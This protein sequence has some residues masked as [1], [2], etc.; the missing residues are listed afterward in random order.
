MQASSAKGKGFASRKRFTGL[1]FVERCCVVSRQPIRTYQKCSRTNSGG[2]GATLRALRSR[3]NSVSF[4]ASIKPR[5][6]ATSLSLMPRWKS[7]FLT[8]VF[9]VQPPSSLAPV[10]KPLASCHF[11]RHVQEKLPLRFVHAAEQLAEL[12]QNAR[13][14]AGTAPGDFLG[15]P[16]PREMTQL[17]GFSPS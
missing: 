1:P 4:S 13:V 15:S 7:E 2:G 3:R 10:G 9:T 16:S 14:F 5:T 8:R 11:L 12:V 6:A 17:G